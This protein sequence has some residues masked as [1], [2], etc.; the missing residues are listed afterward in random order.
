MSPARPYDAIVPTPRPTT[1]TRRGPG[2]APGMVLEREADAALDP[3][4][5]RRQA[6]L[7]R[8]PVLEAVHDPSVTEVEAL[9]RPCRPRPSAR[10]SGRRRSC[11]TWRRPTGGRIGSPR[12]GA[13][14]G[15]PARPPG[16]RPRGTA[17]RGRSAGAAAGRGEGPRHPRRARAARRWK[18]RAGAARAAAPAPSG[19]APGPSRN[20]RR[21]PR[22]PARLTPATGRPR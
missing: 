22:R 16:A 17:G 10:P 14:P 7:Q 13:I 6:A 19:R 12:R 11:A 4:V 21:R 15:T 9:R 2:G 20:R 3:V 8:V 1:P 5:A 18:R